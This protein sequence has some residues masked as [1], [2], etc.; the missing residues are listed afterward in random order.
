MIANPK[1][2][3]DLLVV[4]GG[5][6]G[7]GIACDAAG[8]GLRVALCEQ[9]DLASATSSA[10]TKLIHGGLRYL[11]H[12]EFRLVRESLAEREILMAK[13]PHIVR[14]LRFVLPHR[15][16]ARPAWM[17]RLGL[18][19]YDHLA[20]HPSLPGSRGIDLGRDPAGAVLTE[21][22]DKG[23]EYFDCCVDDAR[24]VVMNA[25]HAARH[26]AR[27][28]TRTRLVGA[29]RDD[30]AWR[31]R[32]RDLR[33]GSEFTLVAGAVVNAAGPWAKGVAEGVLDIAVGK[34]L[35]LVKGSHLVV[36]KVHD[37]DHALIL[38]NTD[39]RVVFVIPF[40][41]RFSLIGTTE[42]P[43]EGDPAAIAAEDTE[44]DYLLAAVNGY[45]ACPV[46]ATDVLW[47]YAGIRPLF[48]NVDD[49]SAI[50]RDYTLEADLGE[51]KAPAVSVFGGKITTYRRLA[52]RV[53]ARLGSRFPAMGKPWTASAP[54]P[55]GALGVGDMTNFLES[56]VAA[57]PD[58]DPD[59]L[60]VLARRYGGLVRDV[61][62][63][64]QRMTDLGGRF[65]AGLYQREIDYLV[66]NEW[67]E[68]ATD[69]L[70]RRTKAG[71]H[72]DATETAALEDYLAARETRAHA[73]P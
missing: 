2:T 6:N 39:G 9:D 70:W 23:F 67:A 28:M 17:V 20:P 8:R 32:L 4:G 27:I 48:G 7:A 34:R 11:E 57:Y 15:N 55:G 26:G 61:L 42:L 72:M 3:I 18:F 16:I 47:S 29:V 19:L 24:L 69:V 43:F 5:I 51:G 30:D 59:Y 36:P 54:L 66:E 33:S 56:L 22:V 1:G 65:G 35:R 63:P 62:G 40:E 64:A 21:G 10:S 53:M 41:G 44:R 31:T 58:L 73:T 49:P 38:Q 60:G 14:P 12:F 68:T 50:T 52:E 45:L 37:G 25:L 71:L 46:R 13:A